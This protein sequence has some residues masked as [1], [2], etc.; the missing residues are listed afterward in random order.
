LRHR[1]IY[2]TGGFSSTISFGTFTLN[3][4]VT[5]DVFLTKYDTNGNV[6]WAEQGYPLDNNGYT[7][8]SVSSDTLKNGGGYLIFE[9]GDNPIYKLMFGGETFN[10]SSA[11]QTAT[12]FVRFDS[13]GKTMCGTIFTEGNEDDGDG[14]G[15]SPS[16][17]YVY[18]AGDLDLFS[19]FGVDTLKYGGDMPFIARWQPCDKITTSINPIPDKSNPR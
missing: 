15:I 6:L 17:K 2:I 4:T 3:N 12:V 14:V 16:G 19:I 13:S 8:Y 5:G 18:L 1:A 10:L 9:G 11:D 7:G